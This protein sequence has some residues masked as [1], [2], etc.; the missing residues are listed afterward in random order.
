MGSLFLLWRVDSA[1]RTLGAYAAVLLR[2][3]L[4]RSRVSRFRTLERHGAMTESE[5]IPQLP[6]EVELCRRAV[7]YSGGGWARHQLVRTYAGA[8]A[9][10]NYPR[11][12]RGACRA[13]GGY[14]RPAAG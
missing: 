6:I 2:R 4:S 14:I 11:G 13:A 7:T 8:P 12:H 1:D 9:P 3:I 10:C 5:P